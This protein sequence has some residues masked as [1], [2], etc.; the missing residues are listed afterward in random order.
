MS[1]PSTQEGRASSIK[2]H[3]IDASNVSGQRVTQSLYRYNNAKSLDFP[4]FGR[5][6]RHFT[7]NSALAVS[8]TRLAAIVS[9]NSSH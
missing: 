7:T 9:T 3:E 4:L 6:V 8:L 1:T 2:E 5:D